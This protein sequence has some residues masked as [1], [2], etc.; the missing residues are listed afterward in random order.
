MA[1]ASRVKQVGGTRSCCFSDGDSKFPTEEIMGVQSAWHFNFAHRFP[2]NWVCRPLILTFWTRKF[3]TRSFS[4]DNF[5]PTAKNLRRPLLFSPLPPPH[6]P[7][8]TPS[9]DCIL[10][11]DVLLQVRRMCRV[12]CDLKTVRTPASCVVTRPPDI[13]TEQW[14]ARDARYVDLMTFIGRSD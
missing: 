2:A 3:P 9:L 10:W 11:C 12:T 8:T 4:L 6:C 14:P 1:A 5:F 13:T 7:A